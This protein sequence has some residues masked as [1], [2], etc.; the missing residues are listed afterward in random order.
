VIAIPFFIGLIATPFAAGALL[1]EYRA[2][3]TI[4][5]ATMRTE[6]GTG[7]SK[8]TTA[9]RLASVRNLVLNESQLEPI[10]REFGLY[11]VDRQSGPIPELVERIRRDI[12]VQSGGGDLVRVGYRN[13]DPKMA[14]AVTAR[15]ASL[16]VGAGSVTENNGGTPE[17]FRI[18]VAP[19]LPDKPVNDVRPKA[20]FYGGLIGL[21][22]GFA[23]AFLRESRDLTLVSEDDVRRTL[24]LPVLGAIS[25][26]SL[27]P[28]RKTRRRVHATR[29]A[30]FVFLLSVSA[31]MGSGLVS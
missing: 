27:E 21:I 22:V 7:S 20:V 31:L 29:G 28:G 25:L 4:A 19:M 3:A 14:Q 6:E 26:M 11:S 30:G 15:L 18:K 24:S 5:V 12:D 8:P 13:Q 23:L 9:A 16:L 1:H 10:I 17:R 2:E